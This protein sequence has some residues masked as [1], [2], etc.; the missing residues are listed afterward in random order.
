MDEDNGFVVGNGGTLLVTNNAG[1]TWVPVN[2]GTHH[3]LW[4]MHFLNGAVG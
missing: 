4:G 3:D 2:S 1:E